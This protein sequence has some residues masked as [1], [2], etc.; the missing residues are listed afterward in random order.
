MMSPIDDALTEAMLILDPPNLPFLLP[1]SPSSSSS[2]PSNSSSSQLL[3]ISKLTNAYDIIFQ[4]CILSNEKMIQIQKEYQDYYHRHRHHHNREEKRRDVQNNTLVSEQV[5]AD[6]EVD[7]DEYD[8][9]DNNAFEMINDEII[10][11]T[12]SLASDLH[13]ALLLTSFLLLEQIPIYNNNTKHDDNNND[14]TNRKKESIDNTDNNNNNISLQNCFLTTCRKCIVSLEWLSHIRSLPFPWW[15]GD[16]DANNNIGNHSSSD[17][18]GDETTVSSTTIATKKTKTKTK[19]KTAAVLYDWHDHG[20]PISTYSLLRESFIRNK[21]IDP[22][23]GIIFGLEDRL[24]S[25]DLEDYLYHHGSNSYDGIFPDY[26]NHNIVAKSA[27]A[28]TTMTT[29]SSTMIN[30]NHATPYD[31]TYEIEDTVDLHPIIIPFGQNLQKEEQT[32]LDIAFPKGQDIFMKKSCNLKQ[33]WNGQERNHNNKRKDGEDGTKG[34]KNRCNG[35]FKKKQRSHQHH[36]LQH[37]QQQ[38]KMTTA[39]TRKEIKVT[40]NRI[41]EKIRME[42]FSKN[43]K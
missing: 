32:L 20:L 35:V 22:I 30:K 39:T 14:D 25:L 7:N 38:I 4:G 8:N 24:C 13:R 27:T 16:N 23:S 2:L 5:V 12:I 11:D 28:T 36:Q 1:S 43:I 33:R 37:R 18:N 21:M 41:L 42:W 29:T 15:N 34:Q 19:T 31:K 9:E 3:T 6:N 40:R 10:N 17:D 26:D